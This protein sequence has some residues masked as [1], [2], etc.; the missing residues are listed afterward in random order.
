MEKAAQVLRSRSVIVRLAR[1]D[2]Y[3]RDIGAIHA[4]AIYFAFSNGGPAHRQ[5]S[6]DRSDR[7]LWP[8]P[9]QLQGAPTSLGKLKVDRA[10]RIYSA[11]GDTRHYISTANIID[12]A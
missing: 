6:R 2:T 9:G 4:S 12:A 10:L 8:A 11:R 7:V 5:R 1:D 3:R